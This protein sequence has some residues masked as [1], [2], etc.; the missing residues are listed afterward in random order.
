MP[1]PSPH[2]RALP[3]G[4]GPRAA[5]CSG[6]APLRAAPTSGCAS[7]VAASGRRCCL[8]GAAGCRP[9]RRRRAAV[10]ASGRATGAGG[11]QSTAASPA[12]DAS[13]MIAWP[14]AGTAAPPRHRHSLGFVASS[15]AT[16]RG[17]RPCSTFAHPEEVSGFG[18][19]RERACLR[20]RYPLCPARRWRQ[21]AGPTVI[22]GIEQQVIDR[23]FNFERLRICTPPCPL[24]GRS[25]IAEMG[26]GLAECG[27]VPR[28]FLLQRRWRRGAGPDAMC[29]SGKWRRVP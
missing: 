24:T 17:C 18:C 4:L 8:N 6:A 1:G 7:S 20:R 25:P 2:Q 26:P 10:P 19:Q 3:S 12:A 22:N 28:P 15:S 23:R 11:E 13:Q 16:R 29:V 9:G 5:A 21:G 27:P 14:A